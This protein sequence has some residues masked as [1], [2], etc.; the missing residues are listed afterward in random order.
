MI[1]LILFACYGYIFFEKKFKHM[2]L[3]V[4]DG[5]N[6]MQIALPL[7]GVVCNRN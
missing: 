4:T 3:E 1:I 2:V 5:N 6:E 7:S